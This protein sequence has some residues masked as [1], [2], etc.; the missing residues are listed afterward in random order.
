MKRQ[1]KL[2]EVDPN[3]CTQFLVNKEM[4]L[5]FKVM[6]SLS[7]PEIYSNTPMLTE[8]YIRSRQFLIVSC[9]EIKKG[10]N[11]FK[12]NNIFVLRIVL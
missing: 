10:K 7:Q 2:L 6:K 5:G 8:F 4:Y 12:L 11:N 1:H 3:D 9:K